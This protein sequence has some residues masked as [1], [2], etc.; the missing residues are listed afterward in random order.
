MKKI[1]LYYFSDFKYF[2]FLKQYAQVR[3]INLWFLNKFTGNVSISAIPET[4]TAD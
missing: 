4:S 2:T 1:L 3:S